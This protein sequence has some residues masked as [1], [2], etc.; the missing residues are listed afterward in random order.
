MGELCVLPF[1]GEH[2]FRIEFFLYGHPTAG[3][4]SS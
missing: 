1:G 3:S 4:F 2:G